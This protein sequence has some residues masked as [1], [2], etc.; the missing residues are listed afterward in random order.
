MTDP[1]ARFDTLAVTHGEEPDPHGTGDVVVPLHLA[2]TF[3]TD[4]IEFDAEADPDEH[5]YTRI[6]NPTRRALEQRL[7]ALEG[8]D[9]AL[10]FASG[11]SAIAVA[12]LGAATPGDHIVAFDDLYGGTNSILND[13]MIDRLGIDVTFVDARDTDAVAAAM[14]L[15]TTLV[16]METPT[17]PL[18]KLCDIE[19]I[20]EIAHDG[21]ALLGVDN[22]FASPYFQR[23]LELGADVVAQSTTKYLNGHSDSL[24]G[25]LITSHDGYYEELE[26]LH[27]VGFGNVLSPFDSYLVLRGTKTLPVR[28]E[29]HQENAMAIA[30][31]LEAQEHVDSINYPGLES[32]PQHD[33]ANRQMSGYGSVLSFELAGGLEAVETFLAHLDEFPL[34]VSLGG[35]ESLI[36]HP[37]SMTHERIPREER[38]AIGIPIHCSGCPSG[39]RPSMT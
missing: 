1:N 20:A 8:G 33:L 24:G 10:A 3:A 7:A 13:L 28:M 16:W 37:A 15:E 27:G 34:A 21:D 39:S 25:A 32:H 26:F 29:R 6:S 2:S 9:H 4:R 11:T 31:Y 38:E 14:Q 35:V 23:P 18:I 19:A 12:M 17:N 5:M 22:T 30:E 36:E